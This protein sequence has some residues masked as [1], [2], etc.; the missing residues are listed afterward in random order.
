METEGA[1]VAIQRAS[2]RHTATLLHLHVI[3]RRRPGGRGIVA[4]WWSS[5]LLKTTQSVQRR[6]N[7]AYNRHSPVQSHCAPRYVSAEDTAEQR[8]RDQASNRC[9]AHPAEA[10]HSSSSGCC[11]AQGSPSTHYGRQVLSAV[12]S[13]LPKRRAAAQGRLKRRKGSREWFEDASISRADDARRPAA[14]PI[15]VAVLIRQ[16]STPLLEV[17]FRQLSGRVQAS[18]PLTCRK[19]ILRLHPE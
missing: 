9:T 2:W 10:G 11:S 7:C 13:S 4:W 6:R 3:R 8:H 17:Y 5:R 15:R 12:G 16:C 18:R 19:S 1:T 14:I